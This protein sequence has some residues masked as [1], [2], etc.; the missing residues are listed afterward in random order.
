PVSVAIVGGGIGGLCL[1][2]GL[3]QHPHLKVTVYEA[4]PA[5]KEIGAGLALGPNAQRAL[6]LISPAAA[7]AFCSQATP[8][9]SA[10]FQRTWF[11]FRHGI[12]GPDDGAVLGKVE[13]E[14]GQQTA[15]RA[16]FLHELVN[17]IPEGVGRFGKQLVRIEERGP[18]EKVVLHFADGETAVADCLIGADGVH[19]VARKH[20]LVNEEDALAAVFSGI[21]AYRGLIPMETAV[22]NLGEFASDSYMWT[23]EGGMVMT[24]PIDFGKTLNV[25]A[26]RY[27]RESWDEPTYVVQSD[28]A[29]LEKDYKGWGDI[30]SKVIE[31]VEQPTLWAML[32][33]PP[34][35]FYNHG[36]VAMMGDAAHATT[37][38]QGAGAGQAIED[39]LVL[40][41][42]LRYVKS[43]SHVAPALAAYDAVRRERSQ[44]V[45]VTSREAIEQYGLDNDIVKGDVKRW[46]DLWSQRMK[47]IWDIDLVKQ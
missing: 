24:Y 2:I 38:F 46:R 47:W 3:L 6:H 42:L 8:N 28:A 22:A 19:S 45:V 36:N 16:K 41:N 43:A 44:K 10:E 9:T 13:N 37:P 12:Q 32:E 1:A 7:E 27:G 35:P 15:H 18:A 11:E 21:V 5:F 25:V 30:P 29:T 14:T 33:H 17:L 34:A 39:A 4:A 20:L 23:G 26:A 40:S 31:M